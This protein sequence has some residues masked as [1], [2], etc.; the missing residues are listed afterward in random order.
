[1][2]CKVQLL[3]QSC[4]ADTLLLSDLEE[5][6]AEIGVLDVLRRRGVRHQERYEVIERVPAYR[7]QHRW[8]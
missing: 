7:L 2:P 6:A 8:R 1:M 4:S 3:F 5:L